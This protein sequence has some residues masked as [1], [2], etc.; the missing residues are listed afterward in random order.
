VAETLRN[1]DLCLGWQNILLI[2]FTPELS[3]DTA[4][5]H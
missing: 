1:T 4:A 2:I 3:A 5:C